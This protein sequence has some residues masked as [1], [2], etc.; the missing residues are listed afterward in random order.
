MRFIGE[1]DDPLPWM[2]ADRRRLERS[3]S[4]SM[5]LRILDVR[6]AQE[7]VVAAY[8]LILKLTLTLT[9]QESKQ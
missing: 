3:L 2:L 6:R 4:D 9:F 7:A 5:W 8:A 1:V